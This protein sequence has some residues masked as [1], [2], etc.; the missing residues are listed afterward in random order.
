MSNEKITIIDDNLRENEAMSLCKWAA[1]R[2]GA[3]VIVPGFG[4]MS[5]VAN[6][7]YMIMKLGSLFEQP[8]GEKAA[9]SLLSSMGTVFLGGRLVTLIP[10]APLQIPIA[11]AT[12]FALGRVV[13]EWLKA[14][15]PADMSPFKKVYE[16][17][18]KYA[19][20][21]IDLFKNDKRGQTPLG[22]EK[23]KF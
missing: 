18:V 19:K 21:N 17:S 6:D 22:D 10:F 11:I 1:A 7:V 4:T 14:G 9:V 13:T 2:A 20:E 16:D 23:R 15:K 8:I 12:T 3:I 5:L